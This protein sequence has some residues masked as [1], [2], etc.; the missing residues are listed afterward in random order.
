MAL[1]QAGDLPHF[2]QTY[3]ITKEI[4]MCNP[5]IHGVCLILFLRDGGWYEPLWTLRL[6]WL[7]NGLSHTHYWDENP[8]QELDTLP[9]LLIQAGQ[10]SQDEITSVG[11]LMILDV[12]M[13]SQLILEVWEDGNLCPGSHC[14][15]CCGVLNETSHKVPTPNHSLL[16]LALLLEPSTENPSTKDIEHSYVGSKSAR[17]RLRHPKVICIV[18]SLVHWLTLI[19]VQGLT[20]S[21]YS[22]CIIILFMFFFGVI[23]SA[24]GHKNMLLFP[25]RLPEGI[26]E[27][28]FHSSI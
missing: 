11:L 28:V 19:K 22:Y 24:R 18:C 12:E 6:G 7:T 10:G 1:F 26:S 5:A 9:E 2:I 25:F 16:P 27:H 21:S 20:Q 15:Y 4:E 17:F 8:S 13:F 23:W 3:D 14:V